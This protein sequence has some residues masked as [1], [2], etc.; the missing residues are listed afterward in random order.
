MLAEDISRDLLSVAV[1]RSLN[2]Q[3]QDISFERCSTGKFNTTYFVESSGLAPLVLRIAPADDRRA[4]LFYEYRM[5]RQEPALHETIGQRTT[6]PIPAI[7][8]HDFSHELF[9]RD[10]LVMERVSG[11]PVSEHWGLGRQGFERMLCQVGES[12]RQVHALRS[13]H[14]GYLGEHRPMEPQ[15]NWTEAFVIMWHKLLDDIQSCGGYNQNEADSM[16]R[17]LESHLG[18]FNRQ[19]PSSLLHMDIWAQNI[20]ADSQGR[21]T[22]LLDWDRALWGDP[23]I[24]FAVLDY[25]GISEPP[26]WEG[27]GEKRDKSPEARIRNVFYLL[28]EL[29]KYIFIRRVR[30]KNPALADQYRSQ[31]LALASQIGLRL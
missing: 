23:E 7:K 20:L 5:M 6:V 25:C 16:R 15:N 19:A 24:E 27:Y 28:Y 26:F 4:N 21:M 12:L 9:D 17:L 11:T 22:G 13:N 3:D 14:Y 2:I 29:Q 30:G 31:S 18:R 8:A 1:T 10:F